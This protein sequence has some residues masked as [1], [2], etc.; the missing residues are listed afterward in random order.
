MAR[1]VNRVIM[2]RLTERAT[3]MMLDPPRLHF[4]MHSWQEPKDLRSLKDLD[5]IQGTHMPGAERTRHGLH[6]DDSGIYR[7]AK[8]RRCA[9]HRMRCLNPERC[10]GC[11]SARYRALRHSTSTNSVT[12]R[13]NTS[14]TTGIV[15]RC[16]IVCHSMGCRMA[17][18]VPEP[19]RSYQ[20]GEEMRDDG[21]NRAR[22]LLAG[23]SISASASSEIMSRREALEKIIS[24]FF[25]RQKAAEDFTSQYSLSKQLAADESNFVVL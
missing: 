1:S 2:A 20:A 3:N 21:H 25:G 16:G 19:A 4:I 15:S 13:V 9:T 12:L 10:Q 11:I 7:A 14:C 17:L 6:K 8:N 5:S 23:G 22:A 24:H 18:C